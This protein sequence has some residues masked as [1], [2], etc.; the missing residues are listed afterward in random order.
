MFGV[1]GYPTRRDPHLTPEH[2]RAAPGALCKSAV[3]APSQ[4]ISA[5]GIMGSMTARF[6]QRSAC[7]TVTRYG[8]GEVSDMALPFSERVPAASVPRSGEI[9]LA[10]HGHISP[11]AIPRNRR[12]LG[13]TRYQESTTHATIPLL[14]R[15]MINS[16]GWRRTPGG[17]LARLGTWSG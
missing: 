14:R 3:G 2:A 10:M 7:L 13:R 9:S 6:P 15:P 4:P 5:A 11:A 8:T 12:A 17:G 16:G 1:H